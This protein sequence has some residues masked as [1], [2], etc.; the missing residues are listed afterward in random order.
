MVLPAAAGVKG[1]R[2]V[3][4]AGG[5]G[6][7]YVPGEVIVKFKDA[8]G[9]EVKAQVLG[10]H[11]ALGL[12]EKKALPGGAALLRTGAD[13]EAAVAALRTDPRVEYAQPNFIYHCCTVNDPLISWGI[14]DAV[15]GVRAEEA[16]SYTHGEG[17]VVAVLDSGV[18]YNHP[19]L[20]DS[21]WHDPQ[22]GTAGY[23]FVNN[24]PDPMD[25]N[26]HGTHVAGIIAAQLN[27]QGVAG[28]A[29][30]AKIMAVKV[31]GADGTGT[32][33]SLVDGIN[34]AASHGAKVVNMSLGWQPGDL[35]P[36]EGD[37]CLYGA[38]K[39]Y[40]G[41]L[42]VAAA[43]NETNDND[44]VPV[45]PASFTKDWP[46]YGI[47]ALPNI[48]SVAA[49]APDGALADFSNYGDESVL[50]AAP[51]EDIVSTVLA[52]DD[53]GVALA[54]YDADHGYRAVFWGF[55]AEDLDD[56]SGGTSVNGA[57]YDAVWRAV[58]AGLGI[59]PAD[60]AAKH[61]LV[62][63]DDQDGTYG[64]FFLP[65]VRDLYLNALSTAGYVYDV[66]DVANGADG[67]SVDA[68]VY[69]GVIWFTGHSVDSDPPND[70]D[71]PTNLT[72]TDQA[73]LITYLT[74][75]GRLFLS[76]RDAGWGIENQPLYADYLDAVFVGENDYDRTGTSY[77]AVRGVNDPYAGARYR[78]T[79]PNTYLDRLK[80]AIG[81]NSSVALSLEPYEAWSGTSMATPFVSAGAAL[82]LSLKGDLSPCQLVD[83]LGG[84]ACPLGSLSGKVASGGK[85]DLAAVTA[86]VAGLSAPPAGGGGGGG[87]GG[88]PATQAPPPGTEELNATGDAQSLSAL[89]GRVNLDLPAGALPDGAKI[90][91]KLA[92]DEPE[93]A[94]A[95]VVAV[96]P[97]FSFETTAALAKPVMVRL[98]YD[99]A[100]LAG[101]DPRALAVFRREA[102]GSWT[103]AGGRL[104]RAMQAVAVELNHFSEYAVFGVRRSFPDVAGH[105]AA[106]DITLLAARGVFDG[107]VAGAFSPDRPATRAELAAF[108]VNLKGLAPVTPLQPTFTDVPP[109]SRYYGAVEAAARAGLIAGL[110][111]GS[112]K[113]DATVTREQMA[114]MLT[115][116]A[117]LPGSGATGAL[118]TPAFAD[119]ADIAPWA[120]GAVTA[121]AVRGLML[122]VAADRFAPKATVTR[123][124]AAAILARLG[125]RLGIFEVTTTV[126][127]TLTWSAVEKPHWELAAGGKV[128]V[129]LPDPADKATAAFLQAHQGREITV[130]GIPAAGPDIYMRGPVLRV[131]G[132]V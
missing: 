55:G 89:D 92:A 37:K 91:V 12:A 79:L 33:A 26:G 118:K 110:P 46:N 57:V 121:A 8:P 103:R 70:V 28:V 56:P 111:D 93:K 113:P 18:D 99:A 71:P 114:A 58:Y 72:L 41:V 47:T 125:D 76:G 7:A 10:A 108:L 11:R 98:R 59:A 106:N 83:I 6:A 73:N 35:P 94:P 129:L 52:Y 51:G 90:T 3:A 1:T 17:I 119:A 50:L 69:S 107:V 65:D 64:N 124:Q 109:T 75:G 74:N 77:C 126:T 120:R 9:A 45:W 66:V 53:A 112:F 39:A 16:W 43:G 48:V 49:L 115:R 24:D 87:G 105:W 97:V 4:G 22:T 62:V 54:V 42:F 116:L 82:A 104:D 130:T 30:G 36:C 85:L 19:D 21:M 63:D 13:V 122:G 5:P 127:G 20:K 95:G 100:K 32:T 86:Y 67:P 128:Y 40:S 101:L 117:G 68:A 131:I 61:L 15:Y 25:D 132:A 23:D 81:G 38:I 29:P 80:P 96:S 123:A 27:G 102:D 2:A 88:A 78:F 84:K 14:T 60:T 34:Y 31:L 44:A